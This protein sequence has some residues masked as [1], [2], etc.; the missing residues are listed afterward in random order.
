MEKR[1]GTHGHYANEHWALVDDNNVP[2]TP[3][4]YNFIEPWGDG[5][6]K[7]EIGA[8]KNIL[9]P[10]GTEV[11]KDGYSSVSKVVNGYFIIERTIR[12]TATT[13]TRYMCGL[14]HVSGII[15][16]QPVFERVRW[17]DEEHVLLYAEYE[18]RPLCLTI[19]GG[20]YD[21]Q[22]SHL[23]KKKTIDSVDYLEKFL[24]WTLPGSQFYY[25]DT[26][27][28]ID[29]DALYH[30][31]DTI[32]AGF[33]VDA[34]TKLL[35][36]IHS[37]RYIIASAHAAKFFEIEELCQQ[38]P[39]VAEWGL[40]LFHK[41][42]YFKVLDIYRLEGVTQILLL[43][44]PQSAAFVMQHNDTI[45]K[46]VN[47][48]GENGTDLVEMARQSLRE[49]MEMEV[50]DRSLDLDLIQRMHAPV[51]VQDNGTLF[52]F[53]PEFE[54]HS[55]EEHALSDF[56]HKAANDADIDLKVETVD[57]FPWHGVEGT[58][59]EGCIYAKEIVENGKGCGRLFEK[60]FR[61]NYIKGKCEYRKVSITIPSDFERKQ[62][63]EQL[64]EEK[65]SDIHAI[66]LIREF[67]DEVLGGD[68]DKLKDFD[69]DT[70]RKN[71]KFGGDNEQGRMRV[72][73]AIMSLAFSD[74]WPDLTVDSVEHCT[75]SIGKMIMFQ[76]L[77][78]S[79]ILDQYFKGMQKFN[80][81]PAQHQR[82]VKVA[83]MLDNIGNMIVMP[84]KGGLFGELNDRKI[85]HYM[86]QFLFRM[87]DVM[88]GKKGRV[89]LDMKAALHKDR[90]LME[91]Y[92]GT[93][94]FAQFCR[95]M[96]LEDF[97]DEN[98]RPKQVFKFVWSMMPDLDEY[99]Y[100]DAVDIFCSF[101]EEFVPQRA[102][103]IVEKLKMYL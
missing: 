33:Y 49:K 81:T 6:F 63:R 93:E 91:A 22:K 34:T 90:K 5:Y 84:A 70:L 68:I 92:Q 12:K 82:A 65:K 83:H 86:D 47:Q 32:R 24:N 61:E 20:I 35:K 40:S 45:M 17:V 15:L 94:G 30:V 42:S 13:P 76:D 37:T 31:G 60:S 64:K 57:N 25:R 59:C 9:R 53:M 71:D 87:F 56:I 10:D 36:P 46:F 39:N 66:K 44:I 101:V 67:R 54:F 1:I 23:P 4:K 14:A 103:R 72:V 88:E 18:G 97:I 48:G 85:K 8:K 41:N 7:S 27:A 73:R 51:G 69:L 95:D 99:A 26:D 102:E 50:H 19:F 21:M 38:N 78:G 52:P 55:A 11:L 16:F 89:S 29:V 77:F 2:V 74:V 43:H 80:P 3:Y 62:E 75:Y 96:M 58:I 100:F 98:G 79:N 28:D